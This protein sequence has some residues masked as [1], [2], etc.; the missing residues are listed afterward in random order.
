M[1][2]INRLNEA[3]FVFHLVLYVREIDLSSKQ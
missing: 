3:V 1:G 2:E